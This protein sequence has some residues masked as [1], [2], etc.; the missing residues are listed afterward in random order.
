MLVASLLNLLNF[1]NYPVWRP[2]IA[3]LILGLTTIGLAM[4]FVER[5]A[6]RLAFAFTGLLILTGTDLNTESAIIPVAFGLVASILAWFHNSA[7]V[8]ISAVAFGTV[9]IFQLAGGIFAS[10]ASA[11][12]GLHRE[13]TDSIS[14]DLPPVVHLLMDSYLGTEGMA[15]IPEFAELRNETVDLYARRGFRLYDQAYSR[16]ANTANSIPDILSFGTARPTNVSQVVQREVP[17]RFKYFDY[18]TAQGYKISILGANFIDL[19]SGQPVAECNQF[20]HS[21]LSALNRFPFSTWDRAATIGVTLASFS[22]LVS[23][24]YDLGELAGWYLAEKQP[25]FMRNLKKVAPPR[26]ALA[27]DDL[28]KELSDVRNGNVYFIHLLMPHEPYIF[29]KECNVKER[30]DWSN[31]QVPG[32]RMQR[33]ANYQAQLQC[34]H[35]LLAKMFDALESSPSGKDAVVIIHGDHG[36]RIVAQ[37]PTVENPSPSAHDFAMTY[38]TLFAVRANG[39]EGGL[40]PGRA[41]I[42]ELLHKFS[43]SNFA[44]APS[45]GEGNGEVILA[46]T[47]WIPKQRIPLPEY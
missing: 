29:D 39:V 34:T 40:V 41:S 18:L 3:G 4:A 13:E 36:S 19:C 12:A 15:A 21:D 17:D 38:S 1:N 20:H 35:R 2:E 23:N 30:A 31:E 32:T 9:A 16:H 47:D 27:M 14:E 6:P 43:M 42:D 28:G 22:S 44:A 26:S 24:S 8:K 7:V 45:V 5:A 25:M 33:H 11:E 37:R 10:P 46:T